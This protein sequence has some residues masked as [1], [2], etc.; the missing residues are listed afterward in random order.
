MLFSLVAGALADVYDRRKVALCALCLAFAGAFMLVLVSY[1]HL[2]KP[3]ML[4]LLCFVI[5]SGQALFGP[6]W[7]SSVSEQVPPDAL[8][9]AVGLNSVSYNIARSFVRRSAAWW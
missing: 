1:C 5:G 8:A 2:M 7:Q 6:A 9:N 3:P 4:L